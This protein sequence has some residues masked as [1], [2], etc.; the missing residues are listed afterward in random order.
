[1]VKL[2]E[3]QIKT[4]KEKGIKRETVNSRIKILNWP[5][6]DAVNKPVAKPKVKGYAF[7]VDEEVNRAMVDFIERHNLT[8]T[9]FITEAIVYYLLFMNEK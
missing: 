8:I 6:E 4:L 2:T 1:L 3:E 7:R 9:N 5:I